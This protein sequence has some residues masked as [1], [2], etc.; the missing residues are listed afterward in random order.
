[1]LYDKEPAYPSAN[2]RRT[3]GLPI[4]VIVEQSIT[5]QVDNLSVFRQSEL[6]SLIVSCDSSEIAHD[7]IESS[8]RPKFLLLLFHVD[9]ANG[10]PP[11]LQ[12]SAL[13]RTVFVHD[14]DQSPGTDLIALPRSLS[15]EVIQDVV[16]RFNWSD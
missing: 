9:M 3:P 4:A 7:C 16:S 5:G 1:M 13:A 6:F 11:Q 14:L 12:P 2:G 8:Q 15:P 10:R